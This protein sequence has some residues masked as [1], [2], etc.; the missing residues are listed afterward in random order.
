MKAKLHFDFDK[1]CCVFIRACTKD[2]KVVDFRY[3]RPQRIS[4]QML[5]QE[6][7]TS[8]LDMKA[9][10]FQNISELIGIFIARDESQLNTFL[11]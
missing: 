3:E 8:F 11:N 7:R 5:T 4:D 6:A 9:K 1:E 10:S 2:K